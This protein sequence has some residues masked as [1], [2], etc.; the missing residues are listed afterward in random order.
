MPVGVMVLPP[1][2]RSLERISRL[3]PQSLSRRK[4]IR[5][6]AVSAHSPYA[7]FDVRPFHAA[8]TQDG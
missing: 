8:N 7:A 1:L 4:H 2:A 3:P 6:D 5:E